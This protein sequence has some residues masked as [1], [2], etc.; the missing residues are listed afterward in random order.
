MI[1][2]ETLRYYKIGNTRHEN[3]VTWSCKNTLNTRHANTGPR[4]T[5]IQEIQDLR[6]PELLDTRIQ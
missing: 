6:I 3:I 5:R 4:D 2:Q 1:M